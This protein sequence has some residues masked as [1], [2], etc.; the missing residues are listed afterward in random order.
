MRPIRQVIPRRRGVSIVEGAIVLS[1][2]L[3]LVFGGLD[4][5]IAATRYNALCESACRAA[6]AAA[7][8]GSSAQKLGTLGPATME[9]TA[10]ASNPIADSFRYLLPTMNPSEVHARVEWTDGTNNPDDRVRVTL[11]YQHYPVLPLFLGY[12]GFSLQS[13]SV[14]AVDH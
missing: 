2:T 8:R 4:L 11:Q 13:I 12:G 14:M 6:R 9:F 5:G 1:V 7:V 3:L 10:D